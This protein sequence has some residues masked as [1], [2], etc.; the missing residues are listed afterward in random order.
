[1]A[2]LGAKIT[3]AAIMS[4]QTARKGA[5]SAAI[6]EFNWEDPL[7]LESGLTQDERMIRD[8]AR[9]FCQDK[10]A[11]RILKAFRDERFD[12]EIMNELGQ[13]GFLGVM[14]AEAYGGSALGYVA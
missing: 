9:A 5:S 11:P 6:A 2:L 4:A 10:L 12:R 8:S 7:D 1:M 13:M 14:T 3:G